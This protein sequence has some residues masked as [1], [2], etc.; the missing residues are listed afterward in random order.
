MSTPRTAFD[1]FFD[2]QMADPE[3]ASAY[4]EAR[5]EIDTYDRLMRA[6]ESLRAR[7]GLSKAKLASMSGLPAQ[8]VRKVLTD[9][10]A[11]PTI[12]TVFNMLNHLGYTLQIVPRRAARRPA[13]TKR[14]P[15]RRHARAAVAG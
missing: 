11:N 14:A 15:A 8:S 2:E 12:A 7:S 4:A 13:S 10:K 9:K 5:V 3:F 6:M 1:D